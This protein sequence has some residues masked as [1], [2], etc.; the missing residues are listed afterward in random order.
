MQLIGFRYIIS[1]I[2]NITQQLRRVSHYFVFPYL[3]LTHS[4]SCQTEEIFTI[5]HSVLWFFHDWCVHTFVTHIS[6]R[7]NSFSLSQLI[8]FKNIV[9]HRT[10]ETIDQANLLSLVFTY[11]SVYVLISF[12]V[13]IPAYQVYGHITSV[14]DT[15]SPSQ[16]FVFTIVIRCS[17]LPLW[18][19]Y[20]IYFKFTRV[21]S[22]IY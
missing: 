5:A 6:I 7:F 13:I 21:G 3:S 11:L 17:R 9:E 8:T 19:S 22:I 2:L 1:L 16:V 15:I 18:V 10:H 14:K 20:F 12:Y 4:L